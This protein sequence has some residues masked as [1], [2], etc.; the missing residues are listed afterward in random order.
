MG[1]RVAVVSVGGGAAI[2]LA[3]QVTGEGMTLAEFAP[4]T[5]KRFRDLLGGK[6]L[7]ASPS[8]RERIVQRLGAN[9]VDLFGD[10]DDERLLAALKLL[11]DDPNTDM[12]LVALYFQVPYLTEYLTERLVDLNQEFKK[13]LIVSPRGFSRHVQR[14]RE[15][16]YS[17]NFQTYTVPM[18]KPMA[19]AADIWKRYGRDFM[20]TRD[21]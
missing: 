9:P 4:E 14:S 10:C 19:I 20:E 13:P 18:V 6:A 21:R 1:D 2:L 3:D 11:D 12:I 15:Y 16:L 8:E 17:K 5:V 7:E